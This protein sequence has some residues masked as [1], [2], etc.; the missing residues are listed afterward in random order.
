MAGNVY[1]KYE[2]EKEYP[3]FEKHNK[4]IQGPND[5]NHFSDRK[6]S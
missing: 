1:Y 6:G 2:K 4:S 5:H 3:N